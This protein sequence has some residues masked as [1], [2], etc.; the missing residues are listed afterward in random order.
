LRK[1]N[2]IL[3]TGYS[4]PSYLSL[5]RYIAKGYTGWAQLGAGT[6]AYHEYKLNDSLVVQDP[7]VPPFLRCRLPSSCYVAPDISSPCESNFSR[8][9]DYE[10]VEMKRKNWFANISNSSCTCILL[11]VVDDSKPCCS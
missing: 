2:S 1:K 9:F 10:N 3:F 8:I 7:N 11:K 6:Q 5:S 4:M